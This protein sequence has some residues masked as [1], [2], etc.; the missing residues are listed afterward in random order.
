MFYV[1]LPFGIAAITG[2]WLFLRD[3]HRNEELRFDW[4][5]FAVLGFALAGLQ[6]MLDRGTTKDWFTSGEIIVEA[7]GQVKRGP[8]NLRL[9]HDIWDIWMGSKPISADLKKSLIDRIDTLG[10]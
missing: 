3:T 9:S 7:K 8:T 4:F 10:R 1:N 6:L 5:G 2:I